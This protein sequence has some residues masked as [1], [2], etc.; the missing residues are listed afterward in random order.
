MLLQSLARPLR[1]ASWRLSLLHEDIAH[2]V[3]WVAQGQG[4]MLHCA[5]RRGVGP[6]QLISIPAMTPFS[7]DAGPQFTGHLLRV[8]PSPDLPWPSHPFSLRGAEV[9]DHA[10]FLSMLESIQREEDRA[11]PHQSEALAALLMLVSIWLRRVSDTSPPDKPTASDKLV[12][13]YLD[14]VRDQHVSPVS[15][16]DI[17]ESLNV[18]PTHLSRVCKTATGHSAADLLNGRKLHAARS[19]LETDAASAKDIAAQ[20]GFGSAAYFSRFIL[21]HTGQRPLEIRRAARTSGTL[22]S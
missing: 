11:L 12:T 3:I 17:A 18:T 16:G 9:S 22:S 21:K 20:L 5:Q 2:R 19:L 10:Q 6:G 7:F 15:M 4:R 1:S 13:R 14:A 8:L